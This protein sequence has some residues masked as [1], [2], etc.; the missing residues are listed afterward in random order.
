VRPGIVGL[1]TMNTGGRGN[2]GLMTVVPI[3]V[4]VI[5]LV[6]L[7]GGPTNAL[8]FLDDTVRTIVYHGRTILSA[9]F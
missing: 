9:W 2:D 3:G 8:E 4:S 7:A 1:N 6:M 5:V